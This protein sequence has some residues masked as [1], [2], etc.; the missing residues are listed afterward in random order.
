MSAQP[1]YPEPQGDDLSEDEAAFDAAMHGEFVT[2]QAVTR[3]LAS[4]DTDTPLPPP[5]FGE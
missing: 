2:H 4:K 5:S 1:A 3:W